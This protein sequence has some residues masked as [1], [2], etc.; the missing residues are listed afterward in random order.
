[1]ENDGYM[2]W[3]WLVLV[4]LLCGSSLAQ[5][6]QSAHATYSANGVLIGLANLAPL[7]DCSIRAIEGKV[8]TVK[9]KGGVVS[10]DLESKSERMTFQFPLSRLASAEQSD[11]QKDF[12]HKGLRLRGEWLR[13]QGRGR[14]ARGDQC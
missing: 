2:K 7:R 1:M 8:K 13:V 4:F 11:F 6:P 3:G 14:S 5:G 12:L 9:E 10:F